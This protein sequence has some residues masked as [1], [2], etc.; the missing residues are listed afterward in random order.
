MV[1][2]WQNGKRMKC[3]LKHN[4]GLSLL[5]LTFASGI[6]AMAL[7]LLF[8]SLISITLVA[9][10]NEDKS[11]A[12]TIL[13]SVLEDVSGKSWKELQAWEAPML[14]QPG[15]KRAVTLACFDAEGNAIP[16]PMAEEGDGEMP[17]LPNPLEIQATLLWSDSRGHVYQ[18]EAT[19]LMAR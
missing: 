11:V 16:L 19:M 8:G 17:P 13:S 5:E 18:S 14:T 7:S 2:I 10:L 6:L 1:Y 3:V 4:A 15:T 12:G 9:R